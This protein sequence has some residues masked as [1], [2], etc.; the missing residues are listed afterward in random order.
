MTKA[1]LIPGSEVFRAEVTA[2]GRALARYLEYFEILGAEGLPVNLVAGRALAE[3]TLA[4]ERSATERSVTEPWG[5]VRVAKSLP[6]L[7]ALVTFCRD[8]P[9]CS[10]PVSGRGA[11]R[12]PFVVVGLDPSLY[13]GAKAEL[14]TGILEKGLQLSR[15]FYYVTTLLKCSPMGGAV[16]GAIEAAARRCLP[17]LHRE[18]SLIK[19]KIVLALGEAVGAHL[20]GLQEPLG[21]LRFCSHPLAGLE[22]AWLRVTFELGQMLEEPAIKKEAWLSDIKIIKKVLE[23]I[24]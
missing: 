12:A 15:E 1:I 16:A 7:A 5:M 10:I 24:L 14:L 17:L 9:S 21:L 18:L 20:S 8:C 3:Q 22:G 4:V 11:A 13:E 19:P 6:E 2:L 23:K